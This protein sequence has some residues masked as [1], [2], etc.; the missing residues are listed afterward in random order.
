[1]TRKFLDSSLIPFRRYSEIKIPLAVW[2]NEVLD[3]H[4]R[5]CEDRKRREQQIYP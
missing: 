1:M 5:E 2:T 4:S 3:F